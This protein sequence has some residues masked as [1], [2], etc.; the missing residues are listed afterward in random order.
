MKKDGKT[1]KSILLVEDDLLLRDL[2]RRRL[3]KED[4]C[5]LEA[6]NGVEG[7]EKTINDKPNLMLLDLSLP[8]MSGM[9][10][11]ELLKIKKYSKK[12]PIIVLTSINEKKLK[13]KCKDDLEVNYYYIKPEVE[14]KKILMSIKQLLKIYE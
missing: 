2:Y 3:E 5:V 11:L 14:P 1:Q 10:M 4:F 6:S 9:E 13:R 7:L 12:L 8:K